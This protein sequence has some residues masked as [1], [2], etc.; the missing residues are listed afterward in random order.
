MDAV[1]EEAFV[2]MSFL[3]VVVAALVAPACG[4]DPEPKIDV[5]DAADYV[6]TVGP[7]DFVDWIDNRWLPLLPGSSWVYEGR[8]GD[9]VEHIEVVVLEETRLV[10]G[11]TAAVVHDTVTVNGELVEDTFD[12]YAQDTAGN[13]WYLGEDSTEYEDGVAVSTAGSWEWGIDGALPG[14]IMWADP[15]VGTAYRQEFYE[16]E[17]EDVAEVVRRDVAVTTRFGKFDGVLVIK[18]WNPMEPGVVEEKYFAAGMGLV[19]EQKIE[20][21]SDTVEL[22]AAETRG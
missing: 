15:Q 10:N 18:E 3:A 17:A 14:I 20:G 8:D 16:D 11:V 12:W 9:E 22:I 2:K 6:V 5:G 21:G 1:R 13:V 7:G 19:L 4:G